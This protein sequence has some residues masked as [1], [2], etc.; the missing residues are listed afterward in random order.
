MQPK[1]MQAA[2]ENK[3]FQNISLKPGSKA[4]VLINHKQ[5][6]ASLATNFETR[7]LTTRASGRQDVAT[8]AHSDEYTLLL[9]AIRLRTV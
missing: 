2:V 8:S 6:F 5:F 1:H 9:E 7:M 3:S 4:D